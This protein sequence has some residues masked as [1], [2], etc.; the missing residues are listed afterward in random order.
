MT[1]LRVHQLTA[2]LSV[3]DAV[4]HHTLEVDA[5]LREMGHETKIFAQHIHPDVRGRAVDYRDHAAAEADV[6]LYQASTGS[7][8][9]EYLLSR[10]EPLILNY[11]NLTPAEMFD[12]WEP[13][14][15]AELDVGRRQ[16]DRLARKARFGIAVSRYNAAELEAAGLSDVMVAPVLFDQPPLR[17]VTAADIGD[18]PT[19][20]FVGRLAPNKCQQDL[21]SAMAVLRERLH[22]ARLVLVGTPAS[23]R[24]ADAL[25]QHADAVCPGAVDFAGSVSDEQLAR[26]YADADV[27]VCLSEH[28]GFCVPVVEAMAAGAPVVAY[29]AAVLPETVGDAG[30]LLDDKSPATVAAAVERVLTDRR[31]RMWLA[32]RGR[33]RA[34]GFSPVANRATVRDA[35]AAA[36]E[37]C[38]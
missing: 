26:A 38:T 14:I 6:L 21:I 24:Y 18:P 32:E 7:P 28:E 2:S 35:L 20:L 13:H 10:P 12:V 30:I 15:G 36:I 4:S 17:T 11:H 23:H 22:D 3:R 37:A 29:A 16:L 27:F 19:V 25:R 9:G 34:A 31:L 5:I 1:A 33:E 8:V